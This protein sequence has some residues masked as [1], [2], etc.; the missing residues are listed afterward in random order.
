MSLRATAAAACSL[1]FAASAAQAATVIYTDR[2]AFSAEAPGATSEAFHDAVLAAGLSINPQDGALAGGVLKDRVTQGGAGTT[3][4]FDGG[5][6]AFGGTFDLSA[7]GYGGG[8]RFSLLFDDGSETLL[9]QKLASV[10]NSFFGFVSDNPFV[11]V[12]IADGSTVRAFRETYTLDDVLYESA[13]GAAAGVEMSP[14][15]EPS[16]WAMAI[17]GFLGVGSVL[18]TRRRFAGSVVG[19]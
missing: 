12:R 9:S 15:P 5:A 6:R 2:A 10:K 16:S 8:L 4:L 13:Q 7:R 14:A 3:L 18:R 19:V 17:L 1:V 11:G